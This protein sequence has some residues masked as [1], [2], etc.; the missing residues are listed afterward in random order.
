MNPIRESA[1]FLI[2]GVS[3]GVAVAAGAFF[4]VP[5][6]QDVYVNFGAQLPLETKLLLT[7]YRWWGIVAVV[8]VCTLGALAKSIA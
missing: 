4:V 3:A 8:T 1:L 7:T 5:Q 6:F 2:F